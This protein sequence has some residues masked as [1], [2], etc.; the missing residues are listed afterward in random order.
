MMTQVPEMFQMF[1]PRVILVNQVMYT[2]NKEGIYMTE[3]KTRDSWFWGAHSFAKI[4]PTLKY[5]YD[6]SYTGMFWAEL[7]TRIRKLLWFVF[8][9]ACIS[10]INAIFIRITIKCS[11]LIVFPMAACQERLTGQPLQV[12]HRRIIY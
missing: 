1:D 5:E 12:V 11:A 3:N 10:M 6:D 4:N 9:F 2:F 7:I 8:T